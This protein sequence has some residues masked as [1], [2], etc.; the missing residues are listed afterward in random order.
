MK[1]KNSDKCLLLVGLTKPG[2][3][4]RWLRFKVSLFLLNRRIEQIPKLVKKLASKY[5]SMNPVFVVPYEG[6]GEY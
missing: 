1:S 2:L 6:I 4:L 3:I 5:E